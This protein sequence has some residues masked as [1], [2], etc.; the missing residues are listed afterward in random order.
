LRGDPDSTG[1]DGE[2]DSE[3]DDADNDKKPA[4]KDKKP[5]AK[6]NHVP[7]SDKKPAAKPDKTLDVKDDDSSE[8][9]TTLSHEVKNLSAFLTDYGTKG[10]AV[11][12]L[13][14][15]IYPVYPSDRMRL[16]GQLVRLRRATT[17]V[18]RS[19]QA[20]P[21]AL[22][23][24][25]L[26]Q[27][28]LFKKPNE[29]LLPGLHASSIATFLNSFFRYEDNKKREENLQLIKDLVNNALSMVISL[30]SQEPDGRHILIGCIIFHPDTKL[31]SF[32]SY[33]GVL[34]PGT[35]LS[36]KLN[37]DTFKMPDNLTTTDWGGLDIAKFLLS[38]VQMVGTMFDLQ[39]YGSGFPK[40]IDM[41]PSMTAKAHHLLLQVR[42][43]SGSSTYGKYVLYGFERL[44]SNR[45]AFICRKYE[46]EIGVGAGLRGNHRAEIGKGYYVDDLYLRRICLRYYLLVTCPPTPLLN[47][48]KGL[49]APNAPPTPSIVLR[50]TELF[51]T[52]CMIPAID[53]RTLHYVAPP[54]PISISSVYSNFILLNQF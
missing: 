7:D 13:D 45:V 38:M 52:S 34:S 1:E 27:V 25:D 11:A 44:H 10:Y 48:G 50:Q 46:Q 14:D 42:M 24:S 6:D 29:P 20:L 4:A 22:S 53:M 26:L 33:L 37:K 54:I 8:D 17:K 9:D 23:T 41:H 51:H 32:V 15:L 31:G 47:K 40:R 36:I 3:G 18:V 28:V 21:K 5:A 12:N 49:L 30:T 16:L 2:G 43:E 35:D 19:T 39:K